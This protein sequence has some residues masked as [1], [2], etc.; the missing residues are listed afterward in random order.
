M[1]LVITHTILFVIDDKQY[2][3]ITTYL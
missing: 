3:D 2:N 1:G